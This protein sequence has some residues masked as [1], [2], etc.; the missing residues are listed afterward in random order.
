MKKPW[1]ISTT[2]RNP[3]RLRDFLRVLKTL[4]GKEFNEDNQILFQVL[5]IKER[6]YKPNNIPLKY[7]KYYEDVERKIPIKVARQIFEYQE[8]QDPP[9]RGRQSVNPLNK[10]GFA[11]ARQ[12]YDS[13]RITNLGNLFLNEDY[14]IGYIFFRS[15]LKLQFPNPWSNDFSKKDGFNIMPLIGVLHLI[16]ELDRCEV[17]KGLSKK[18]F[19]L[20]VPTLINFEQIEEQVK[21]II[22]YRQQKGKT[23]KEKFAKQYIKE[24]YGISGD[25]TDKK[26][27]NIFDYGDNIIRY[28]RLTKYLQV[29]SDALGEHWRI[30]LEPTRLTQIEQIIKKYNGQMFRFESIK[31]Y[32]DW[33]ADIDLPELPWEKIGKLREIIENLRKTI[34]DYSNAKGLKLDGVKKKYS[35]SEKI[36]LM[37]KKE[38]LKYLEELRKMNLELKVSE[39]KKELKYNSEQINKTIKILEDPKQIKKLEPEQFEKLINDALLM[40]DDEL[41]I[42]P[43]FPVDDNGEPISHAPGKKAD[44][45]CYY[46]SFNA[47]CEVTLDRSNRQWVR[48]T[49]PVMRHL[50]EFENS[51]IGKEAICI[52]IAPSINNDTYSIF[53][54]SVV[55][56]YDG[57]K[58][59]IVPITTQQFANILR[60][61]LKNIEKEEKNTHEELLKLF[62]ELIN[63]AEVARGFTEW[64]NMIQKIVMA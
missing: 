16:Y 6:L 54:N 28:L 5:L 45:E 31:D 44:I 37:P 18:E 9:M 33:I 29:R 26:I 11:I 47:T 20:F 30:D 49:Q 32:L 38:L 39:K 36:E 51:N 19:C 10:L 12:G 13:I 60:K 2:V 22:N 59:K 63:K 35:I 61:L 7:K 43:N 53:F 40:I 23:E 21:K 50:R 58:Q 41:L 25:I 4:E 1:S 62:N 64:A 55:H 24:F 14:D 42:K 8:Y 3:E 48:E 57:R 34:I 46:E 27:N 17:K 56:E 15:L 52:F